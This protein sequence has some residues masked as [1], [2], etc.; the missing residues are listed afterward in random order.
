MILLDETQIRNNITKTCS[1]DLSAGHIGGAAVL[2]K[3]NGETIYQ[4]FFGSSGEGRDVTDKTLFRLASMTKPITAAAVLKE[5]KKGNLSLD[6]TV[7]EFI[8]EYAK[9]TIGDLDENGE[10][11]V[12]G[13]AKS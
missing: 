6:S 2:V 5:I 7:D 3:Q 11:V 12:V 13:Q 1:A 4:D 8:P 9:M 10:I